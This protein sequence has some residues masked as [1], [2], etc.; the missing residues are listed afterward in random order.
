[1]NE[2]EQEEREEEEVVVVVE[3]EVNAKADTKDFFPIQLPIKLQ[4]K[5]LF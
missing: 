3:D 2:E 4:L 1:M 5:S